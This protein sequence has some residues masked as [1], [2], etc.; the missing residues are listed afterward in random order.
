[1][2]VIGL[3][4]ILLLPPGNLILLA[5]AG[6]LV[7]KRWPRTSRALIA[8]SLLLLLVLSM[9]ACSNLLLHTLET[10]PPLT[11]GDFV[12]DAGAI[13]I[14]SGDVYSRA[15]EYGED[16]VGRTSLERLRYGAWLHR[17][18]GGVPLLTTGGIIRPAEIPLGEAM[19]RILR[20]EFQ[21]PVR[22][23]ETESSNTFENAQMSAEILRREG[24]EKIYL[25]TS[26]SHMRRSKAAFDAVGLEVVP[27]PTGFAPPL[28]PFVG[29][30]MPRAKS[31]QRSA[32]A[33][34][35]WF[36]LLWYELAYL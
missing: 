15:P 12:D 32:D 10:Y 23:V 7:R 25:V 5:A 6:L 22:W 20:D 34:Y 18:T 8:A 28:K 27:A 14:L 31:L 2:A 4:K 17:A 36:G 26:A 33:F 11:P 21:L 16:T 1:M 24:I 3:L 19:A 13:V 30:F 29:D 9:P 35:E